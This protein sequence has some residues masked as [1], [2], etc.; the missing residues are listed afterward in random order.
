MAGQDAGDD[1]VTILQFDQPVIRG[2]LGSRLALER[3]LAAG[4][5]DLACSPGMPPGST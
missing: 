4:E 3:E 1:L 5:H 2:V